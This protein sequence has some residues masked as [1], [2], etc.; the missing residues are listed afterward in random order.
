VPALSAITGPRS[1]GVECRLRS[2]VAPA[3]KPVTVTV[4]SWLVERVGSLDNGAPLESLTATFGVVADGVL[5]ELAGGV[6]EPL[7]LDEPPAVTVTVN[8]VVLLDVVNE[9]ESVGV[10]TAEIDSAP[11]ALN[12]VVVVAAPDATATGEPTG[13]AAFP[14]AALMNCTLPAAE[15]GVTAA[16]NVTFAPTATDAGDADT[17]VVV[18]VA[19]AAGAVTVTVN[20]EALVDPMN[21]VG[22]VGMKAA[23]IDSAP[24]ELNEVVVVAIPDAT[25]IGEPIGSA[26]FMNCTLPNAS[27]GVTVAVN[28]T[29]TPVAT[30]DDDADTVVVVVTAPAGGAVTVMVNGLVLDEVMNAV[31]SVGVK[32]AVIDS[33]PAEL[34]DVVVVAIPDA[35]GIGEP[36]GSAP[37]MNCTRPNAS[38]GVTAADNVTL[39]PAATD[40]GDADTV[41]VVATAGVVTVTVVA[42][43][44][45]A[46]NA[47]GSAGVKTAV[48]ECEPAVSRVADELADPDVTVTGEPIAAPSSSNCTEP[49]ASLGDTVADNAT[50]APAATD[51]G[52]TDSVVVV[53]TAPGGAEVTATTNGVVLVDVVN[54]LGS[55]G[56][57]TAVI[58]SLPAELKVVAVLAAPDDTC[59]GEPTAVPPFLN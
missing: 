51:G 32:T 57:N 16:D 7:E 13:A 27:L 46:V 47:V 54:A 58:D 23:V 8:G 43:L 38:L 49:T 21:A 10:K 12:V 55:V 30:A 39:A 26:P 18:V 9:L 53:A 3:V 20:A 45:D 41:V 4:T 2:Y 28:V 35:T 15:L 33:V 29:V 24:P 17:V 56:V 59:T 25:G 11:T 52:V 31:E 34:N 22:S 1:I 14:P 48:T 6:V 5:V 37:F 19:P 36:I 42:G 44:A 40:A 50:L